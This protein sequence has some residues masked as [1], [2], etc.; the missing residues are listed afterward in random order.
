MKANQEV[1]LKE[2]ALIQDTAIIGHLDTGVPVEVLSSITFDTIAMVM[3]L[4]DG[5]RDLDLK[6]ID[7]AD[8]SDLGEDLELHDVIADFL[9]G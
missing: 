7:Q 4:L 9:K 1:F 5:Y 6:L 2:L 3:E 8:G